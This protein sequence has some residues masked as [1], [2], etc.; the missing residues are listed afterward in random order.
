MKALLIGNGPSALEHK[1]GKRIDSD[2]FDFICRF[3]RG[4]KQDDGTLN[5]GFEE[6]TGTRCDC[7]IVSDL[8][9]HLAINRHND[10]KGI[11]IVTPK[12]KWNGS[13]SEKIES[14]YPNIQFI[15]PE[16]EDNINNIVDFSPKWPSTGVVG[17][18]AAVALFDEVYIYGFDTYDI[19]YD[20]HHYF[21]DKPNK[22]KNASHKDH[23]PSKEKQYIKYMIENKN[24]KLL[25]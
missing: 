7:W 20:N 17:I 6:H 3:N 14:E 18:H 13:L 22:Y 8:R 16:Y 21:E 19:K 9:I 2:E 23:D 24:L 1:M 5:V 11:F 10:Y 25:K 4:H 12:F 15:P